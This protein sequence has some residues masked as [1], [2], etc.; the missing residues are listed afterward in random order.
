MKNLFS[1]LMIFSLLS[2]TLFVAGCSP[3]GT[4]G[5]GGSVSLQGAGASFPKPIYE[6]WMNE[7]GKVNNGVKIDYQSVGSGAGQNAIIAG[8]A[9]FGASDDP[10][11]DEDLKKAKGDLL[12]IPT[13][14][15]AV[16][17]TYNLKEVK[18]PLKL[19]SDTIAG[20]FLGEIKKWNDPRI[21][22][23]NPG[24]ELP[25]TEISPV[26][27]ADSSGTTAVFTDYLAKTSEKFKEKVGTGK[28]PNWVQGVGVGAK[29]NDGVMGQVKNTPNTIGYVEIAF[30]KENKLPMAL[31][32]NKAGKFVEPSLEN[33]S[34]A[35]EGSAGN[36][37]EDLR[38]KITNADGETAYP[39][40]SY[41]YILAFREQKDAVKG[42]ALADFLW[43]ALHDGSE[44]A[45]A[46][47]YAPLPE[48][49]LK[50]VEGKINSISSGGKS[51]REGAE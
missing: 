41:T 38:M 24:A 43:W 25:D 45:K 49:V 5:K 39:I 9:D 34:A 20:I 16:V 12:H 40:A 11:K 1:G 26:Y 6:K 18:E 22:A 4:G 33:V 10:M 37:P 31:I 36:M 3:E 27:R 42:K 32:K 46:L 35:A 30:A 2:L 17:L 48:A 8:T 21:A 44:F 7:Y 50:K 15:G 13:V 29:G 47:H 23:E 51:L 19:T 14:L 28:Q